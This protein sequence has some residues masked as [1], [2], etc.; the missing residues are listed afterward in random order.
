[1]RQKVPTEK[2]EPG[3]AKTLSFLD[4]KEIKIEKHDRKAIVEY[5]KSGRRCLLC[6][7]SGKINTGFLAKK[8]TK[9]A[10]SL[11]QSEEVEWLD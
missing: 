11:R 6:L 8:L 5:Q 4:A 2:P 1:V 7:Q 9:C 10:Q 3:A